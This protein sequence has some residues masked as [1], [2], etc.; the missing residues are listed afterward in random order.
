MHDIRGSCLSWDVQSL[1]IALATASSLRKWRSVCLHTSRTSYILDNLLAPVP[2][3]D[4]NLILL[5]RRGISD[6][7]IF[8]TQRAKLC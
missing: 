6:F 8:K 2:L 1:L 4:K 3:S 5:I 7:M